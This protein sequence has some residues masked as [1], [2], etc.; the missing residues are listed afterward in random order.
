[1]KNTYF[2]F[3]ILKFRDFEIELLQITVEMRLNFPI[4]PARTERLPTDTNSGG[5]R[6][7]GQSHNFPIIA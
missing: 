7:G 5:V 3:E 6:S 2:N 1:M 4:S